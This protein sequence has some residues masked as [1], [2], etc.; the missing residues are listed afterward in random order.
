MKSAYFYQCLFFLMALLLITE[1]YSQNSVYRQVQ[2]FKSEEG[3]SVQSNELFRPDTKSTRSDAM[4]KVIKKATFLT[5]NTP[6]LKRLNDSQIDK[7]QLKLP[8]QRENIELELIRSQLFTEDFSVITD[9]SN[10]K[11]VQ[12]KQG[13][14]FRGVVKNDPNS[15]VTLSIYDDEVI[16]I[17]ASDN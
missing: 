9:K 3:H 5:L 12:I 10:G 16:G 11:P 6:E 2:A 1:S 13:A 14:Y 15:L 7:L 17:I 8:Y 4:D